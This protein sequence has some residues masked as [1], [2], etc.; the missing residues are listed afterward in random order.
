MVG[1]WSAG[2]FSF[3]HDLVDSAVKIFTG[4]YTQVSDKST[5]GRG[6]GGAAYV[7]KNKKIFL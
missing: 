5:R 6:A 7:K 2:Q 1:F 4:G 3:I